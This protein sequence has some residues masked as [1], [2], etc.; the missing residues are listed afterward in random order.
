M[1]RFAC[2]SGV[3]QLT[4]QQ[5]ASSERTPTRP[6]IILFFPVAALRQPDPHATLS[7]GAVPCCHIAV[8]PGAGEIAI[9]AGGERQVLPIGTPGTERPLLIRLS[10]RDGVCTCRIGM[11]RAVEVPS[12][13]H[14]FAFASADLTRGVSL[15]RI[16]PIPA[17][18]RLLPRG[19]S[20]EQ[21]GRVAGAVDLVSRTAGIGGWIVDL[22]QPDVPQVVELR[23]GDTIL[24]R[25]VA[26]QARADSAAFVD[27]APLGRFVFAWNDVDRDALA[28]CDPAAAIVVTLPA[29]GAVLENVHRPISARTA[30]E[31]IGSGADGT[32][33]R[34]SAVVPNWNY[35]RYLPQRLNSLFAQAEPGAAE[36]IV[37]DDAS[38]DD[39]LA[40]TLAVAAAAKREVQI[41]TCPTNSGGVMP[42]WRRAAA[43]ARSEFTMIAE[44]DDVADPALF[45][46]LAAMLASRPD[47]L[48]AFCDSAQIDGEGTVLRADHKRY[49]A[50]L[51]D[52][53][54]EREQIFSAPS[55]LRRFLLPRN[56]VVNAS[57]VLWRTAALRNAMTR[58]GPELDTF[59]GAGDW[60]VYIEACRAGGCVGYLPAVLN[61]FRR[62]ESSTLGRF[63]KADHFV[64]VERIH[65][66]LLELCDGEEAIAAKLAT[67]RTALRRLWELPA[68]DAAAECA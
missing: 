34:I 23:C 13:A 57:A 21:A 29:T 66:L 47:M 42:Q 38:T 17:D 28:S 5:P 19:F 46:S 1:V 9:D 25:L 50:A 32:A 6:D 14:A 49:Y 4:G 35:A 41:V 64:E 10:E 59:R 11:Q 8:D 40:V 24:A 15:D 62:H 39:S 27:R 18:A 56:L 54:L 51:G 30:L 63:T 12:L 52:R 22:D 53:G 31:F 67:H 2:C 68:M 58:V 55:F 65:A 60:R 37:L 7:A 33:A 44:A 43:L 36:I 26:D 20:A 16:V 3:T 45:A 48:F 61:Q